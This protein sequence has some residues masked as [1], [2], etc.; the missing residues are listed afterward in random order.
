[1]AGWIEEF[2]FQQDVERLA[3]ILDCGVAPDETIGSEK[4]EQLRQQVMH[5]I[6][7]V[8]GGDFNLA[9]F[10]AFDI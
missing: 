9:Q 3:M 7:I 2:A 10:G 5:Y 8:A 6:D 4:L 1:M